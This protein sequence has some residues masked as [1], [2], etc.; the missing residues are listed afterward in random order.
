MNR[1][2]Q[3]FAFAGIALF[4]AGT[5]YAQDSLVGDFRTQSALILSDA[6][7]LDQPTTDK[8]VEKY[9][10]ISGKLWQEARD[11]GQDFQ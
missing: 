3:T 11:N 5:A 9:S 8:V 6:L 10:E 4:I 7:L 1:F 2:V